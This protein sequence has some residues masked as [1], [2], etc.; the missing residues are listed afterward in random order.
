MIKRIIFILLLLLPAICSM[1][2][3]SDEYC[4]GWDDGYTSGMQALGKR[5]FTT[6]ICPIPSLNQS[7]YSHGFSDGYEKATGKPTTVVPDKGKSSGSS[8]SDA[9]CMGWEDGY[10]AAKQEQNK[11]IFTVP[12]CPVPSATQNNYDGGFIK[13]YKEGGGG[14]DG[15]GNGSFTPA[16]KDGNFCDGWKKGYE[17]GLQLWAESNNKR[18]PLKITPVCPVP[19]INE[20]NYQNGFEQGKNRAMND[21]SR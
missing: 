3:K 7:T 11:R 4:K 17:F 13:G 19:G 16:G 9:F 12:V 21:M 8:S 20:N 1:A 10:R 2:Q 6:P 14:S 18:V 15:A 5:V